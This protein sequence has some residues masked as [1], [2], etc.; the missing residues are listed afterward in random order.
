MAVIGITG[1]IGCGKSTFAH[2]LAE[3]LGAPLFDTDACARE[4]LDSDPEVRVLV[5]RD[6]LANA[7]GADGRPDR[8]AIRE[9]VFHNPA[10]KARLEKI[11]H[12]RVRQR[13]MRQAADHRTRRESFLVEIPLLFETGAQDFFDHTLTVA[14][15]EA[16][17][18]HRVTARGLDLAEARAILRN[19][20]PITEKSNRSDLVVWNDGSLENL[21]R[22]A[23]ESSYSL[24]QRPLPS[25]SKHP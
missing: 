24:S 4:L 20:L 21:R 12:P 5:Q 14:C 13:W 2:I 19:Q 18:L 25:P 11:L 7:Y 8:R 23:L 3:I 1:G 10:A 16:T 9:L 15:S 6:I 22:Q 17:Q